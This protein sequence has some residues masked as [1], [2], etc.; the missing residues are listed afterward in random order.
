MI[1][2]MRNLGGTKSHQSVRPLLV[3]NNDSIQ[4]PTYQDIEH[5][6]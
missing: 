4:I 5:Y 2:N 6:I 1:A 3:T